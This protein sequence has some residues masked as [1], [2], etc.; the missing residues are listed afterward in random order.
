M[1][2]LI[3]DEMRRHIPAEPKLQLKSPGGGKEMNKKCI[4][5]Y[6][7]ILHLCEI[8]VTNLTC[9]LKYLTSR[10]KQCV[11]K[12]YNFIYSQV[13]KILTLLINI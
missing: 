3:E 8:H 1:R 6:Q 13:C 9:K 4:F 11:V 12:K 5:F 10:A 2:R 7:C